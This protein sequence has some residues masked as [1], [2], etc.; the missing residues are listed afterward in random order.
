MLLRSIAAPLTV[1]RGIGPALIPKLARLGIQNAAGLL[2]HY[3]RDWE[4][5]TLT[6]PISEFQNRQVCTAVTVTARGWIGFGRTRTLKVYV[7][8]E[9][10]SAALLCFNRPWLD[11]Q[12][13]EGRRFRLWGRFYYRY[14][15]IQS[16]SFEVEP[17]TATESAN[18]GSI[19]PVYPLSA[20]L[21]HITL[22]RLVNSALDQYAAK[23]EDELPREIIERDN[24]LPKAAAI[25]AIHFPASAAELEMAKKTLIYEELFYLEIMV[26][27]RAYERRGIGNG[28]Q[29][30]GSVVSKH[31]E[32]TNTQSQQTKTPVPS[33]QSLVPFPL[34]QRLLER[35]PFSLTPGQIKA[36][37]EINADMAGNVSPNGAYSMARLLQGDVGSGKTLVSF[38][39]ALRAAQDGGQTALMAPTELLA[40]QHAENAA[41]LLEPLGLRIA[42]L[43]GNIKAA[44]RKDL[45]RH[46]AS[47]EIDIAVGTH[48][49]FSKDVSYKNLRLVVVDEQHRFGVTQRSLIMAKGN[50]PHLL[51]MSATPIPRT[52]AFTVFGDMDVS[53]IRDLPPGRKPVKTHLAKESSEA[54]VYD[55]VR[56][57]LEAGSQAYFVYPLIEGGDEANQK[58]ASL[59]DAVSMAERLAQEVFPRFT[60][61]LIHSKLDDEEKRQT[62]ERFRAGEIVVL[63]AT[64]VVEVGVD[65]PN[66]SC[67]VI[68]HAERFGLSALHQLRGRVG[69]GQDQAYCFLVYSN[70]LTE[71][72]KARLKVML[73]NADGFIIAEEDLKLR[74]PGQIAG[75][76]Q[77]GY[78]NLGIANPIRDIDELARARTDAFFIL[79]NDPGLVLDDHRIIARVLK[80]AP[81]F[82][83]VVL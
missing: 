12:L 18:S 6:V 2:C 62:M 5:R 14:G 82:D 60:V 39:A 74:G 58:D 26:G 15:E 34:Q 13:V 66:A 11:K 38:L 46:L 9:S 16:S 7:E 67:M 49:L 72:G 33:P 80:E 81:L 44:G 68:E 42:Y 65:V 69:R 76:E 37:A 35:L 75:I 24:L 55:F 77:S 41:R 25:R 17:L 47:G 53:V 23:L 57:K 32:V 31:S 40:R 28:E 21:N 61:A 79:N 45:L 10:G 29:G 83:E 30:T 78:L 54:R 70:D 50:N 59:K 43:T 27:K 52:L 22:R 8:D 36:I 71:D 64:S 51:M 48:A 63:V 3:P 1:I 56:R 4:D 20:G 19:L 73:E